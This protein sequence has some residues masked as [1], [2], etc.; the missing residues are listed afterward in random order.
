EEWARN[1]NHDP[2]V[3]IRWICNS[4][5]YGLSSV[6]NSTNDKPEDEG[7]FAR[8][9]LKVM[10]PEQ[11]FDSLMTATEAK[12]GQAKTTREELRK[13][14]LDKLIVNFGDDEGNEGSFNGTVVQA[15]MLMNG[16]DINNAIMDKETGTAALVMKRYPPSNA[17]MAAKAMDILF[18]A[19][20][21]R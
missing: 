2:R 13:R 12:L 20:L 10:T 14:W 9:L 19:A 1:Y 3:L 15:L 8:I 17:A 21:N 16:A 18:K 11:L 5:A 4:R 6:A 7:H